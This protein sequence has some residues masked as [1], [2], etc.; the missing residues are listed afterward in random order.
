[1]IHT[2]CK[3]PWVREHVS[4]P[5]PSST[6]RTFSGARVISST[7][8]TPFYWAQV[9]SM[10]ERELRE[11]FRYEPNLPHYAIAATLC[12]RVGAFSRAARHLDGMRVRI[13]Y[14]TASGCGWLCVGDWC[15][16]RKFIVVDGG[17]CQR[18]V[19]PFTQHALRQ[20][21]TLAQHS[22][23][24]RRRQPWVRRR[25]SNLVVQYGAGPL[26]KRRHSSPAVA[27]FHWVGLGV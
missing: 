19:D 17:T 8:P 5:E 10:V 11:E 13:K 9:S 20:N 15:W 23:D 25:R 16:T 21:E 14:R 7:L 4:A 24:C 1:M 18:F 3:E 6:T 26:I 12:W 22:N 27:Y 2:A